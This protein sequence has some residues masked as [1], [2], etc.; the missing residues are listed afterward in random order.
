MLHRLVA[1][2]IIS[3][4]IAMTTLLVIQQMYPETANINAVPV[5]FVGRLVFQHQQA[6]DLNIYDKEKNVGYL[7]IQP[8]LNAATGDRI[9]EL[10]GNIVYT[11]PGVGGKR[12]AWLGNIEMD[13]AFSTKRIHLSVSLQG[14]AQQLILDITPATKKVHYTVKS[15][16][17]VIDEDTLT[18]DEN[19]I[20]TLLTQAGISP[21][22]LTQFTGENAA[23]FIPE[24]SAQQSSVTF[25]GETASTFLLSMKVGGQP[26]IEAHLSQLGQVL[27]AGAPL[28]GYRL[29]PHNV[30]P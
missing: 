8:R 25:N 12:I 1:T 13:G 9:V 4:W 28:F 23:Q 7:H 3:F 17:V 29:A 14:P 10:S 27:K 24:F 6:S 19:G 20:A 30:T 15:A 21:A 2:C 18:L 16:A 22:M 11:L 26:L 5:S